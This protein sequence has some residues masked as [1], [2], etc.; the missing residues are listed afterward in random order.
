MTAVFELISYHGYRAVCWECPG[1]ETLH[2]LL[3]PNDSELAWWGPG[4]KAWGPEQS[5]RWTWNGSLTAPTVAP[6]VKHVGGGVCH[7]FIRVGMVEFCSDCEHK[8]RGETVPLAAVPPTWRLESWP[9]VA[10]GGDSPGG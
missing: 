5:I 2:V 9:P 6:S 3:A 10:H 8:L 7:Y 1:C 4:D